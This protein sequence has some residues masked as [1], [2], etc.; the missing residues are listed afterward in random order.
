MLLPT[1]LCLAAVIACA[2][3]VELGR[4]NA[5]LSRLPPPPRAPTSP[6]AGA[7][8]LHVLKRTKLSRLQP[9]ENRTRIL[10]RGQRVFMSI[11]AVTV[12]P[13]RIVLFLVAS[14]G[15]AGA[16]F[17]AVA[18]TARQDDR[19]PLSPF[20]KLI[21]RATL[22][23]MRLLFFSLGYWR[24]H[25]V[26]R[27]APPSVAPIIVS[28]HSSLVDVVLIYLHCASGVSKVENARIPLVG[29][30]ARALRCVFV[31]RSSVESRAATLSE[32]R[33]RA[34]EPGWDHLLIFPEATTTNRTTVAVFRRGAF[35]PGVPVQPVL[36]QYPHSDVDPTLVRAG[37]QLLGLIFRLMTQ[38]YNSVTVS[39][40]PRVPLLP[41]RPSR[42][43]PRAARRA[44]IT[45][46]PVYAPSDA[47][48]RDPNLY[49]ENVRQLMAKSLGVPTA[50][51]SY[52]DT[53]LMVSA[54]AP[55]MPRRSRCTR[56]WHAS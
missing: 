42:R 16:S 18:G 7:R 26:G 37:P 3:Y 25:V 43:M 31:D 32:L 20:R 48:K 46:L 33:R 29:H 40:G 24:L 8:K 1:L 47:E 49:A 45:Y 39:C 19:R 15:I 23:F 30:A 36:L 35:T 44:Q 50:S 34:T 2:V 52:F 13:V 14:L 5:K 6:P 55:C 53:H 51:H 22:P 56:P 10:S 4:Q 9:F 17:V 11:M 38:P 54:C 41:A 21:H 28:N 12:V 27:C